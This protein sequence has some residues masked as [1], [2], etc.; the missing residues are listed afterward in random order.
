VIY[1]DF[2]TLISTQSN[3]TN[4]GL[5]YAIS[6]YNY[7]NIP[8]QV[9]EEGILGTDLSLSEV[10]FIA[11]HT[12]DADLI[13]TL[14]SPS[15]IEVELS[16]SNGGGGYNYGDASSEGCSDYAAF[17]MTGADGY[18][19]SGSAPFIGSYIPEGDF[20]DFNDESTNAKGEWTLS[21]YD[22][23]S[24]DSGSVEFV[25]LIFESL[26]TTAIKSVIEGDITIYPNPAKEVLYIDLKDVLATSYCDL[27]LININGQTVYQKSIGGATSVVESI[28]TSSL[29]S[30]V[31]MV[32]VVT[33]EFS[34]TYKVI[35]E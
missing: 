16:S 5:G 21:V 34:K 31:Y 22:Q 8:I 26:Y 10:R 25:E 11:S 2:T 27:K 33:D 6:D 14:I 30:G 9:N 32:S 18:I 1:D 20:E 35:I 4:C 13:I 23:F 29:A 12:Y 28:N 7:T 24:G 17:S 3:P 15:N 19:T